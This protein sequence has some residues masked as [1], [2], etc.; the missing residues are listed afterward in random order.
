MKD[1]L[2]KLLKVYSDDN[3]NL[4]SSTLREKLSE[5]II[6]IVTGKNQSKNINQMNLFDEV[7]N[8]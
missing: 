3:A 5:D 8:S 1:S 2:M 6:D 4:A 7:S